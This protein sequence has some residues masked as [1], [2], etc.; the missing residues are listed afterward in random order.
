MAMAPIR[1]PF[2]I[3]PDTRSRSVVTVLVD[4]LHDK[5]EVSVACLTAHAVF[6]LPETAQQLLRNLQDLQCTRVQIS[7]KGCHQC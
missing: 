1:L 7:S 5:F 2:F 3:G 4:F 6:L